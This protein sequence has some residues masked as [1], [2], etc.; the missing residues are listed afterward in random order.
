M[1]LIINES[2]NIE[3]VKKNFTACYPFLKIELYRKPAEGTEYKTIA[4]NQPLVHS[5]TNKFQAEINIQAHK[6][7]AELENDFLQLGLKAK[8]FRKSGNVWVGTSL[9]N[10]WTLQQQ[11]TEA[12]EL[13]RIYLDQQDKSI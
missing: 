9:T 12:E 2:S 13:C 10:N 1:K 3:D 8:I 11:N 5:V 6:T 4:V 7:V